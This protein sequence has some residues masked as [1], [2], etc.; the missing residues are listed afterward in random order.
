VE[1][2]KMKKFVDLLGMSIGILVVI[3]GFI[4]FCLILIFIAALIPAGSLLAGFGIHYILLEI[5][6]IP[7]IAI[8]GGCL[9][10]FVAL[11]PLVVLYCFLCKKMDQ[12]LGEPSVYISEEDRKDI[13][14]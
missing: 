13:F 12:L 1:E 7:W 11:G 6:G 8:V 14:W 4:I 10:A 9:G 3:F 2:I 5:F